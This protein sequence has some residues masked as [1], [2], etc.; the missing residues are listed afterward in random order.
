VARHDLHA[1]RRLAA[2]FDL[3]IMAD[4]S[5]ATPADA[6]EIVRQE[7]ADV[8]ALKLTKAGGPWATLQCAAIAQAAGIP[9]YGGC[10]LES[11]VGTAAYL[12]V[13]A[14]L[15]GMTQGCELFGPLL[16]TDDILTQ[17][18][19]YGDFAIHLHSG[20]GFGVTLDEDKLAHYRRD[21]H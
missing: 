21:R 14:A 20:P 6:I 12:H 16:L 13:F 8:F 7:A 17:P 2:R 5:L 15:G 1:M 9:L 4:E 10:M 11:G 18:L 19:T 3:A